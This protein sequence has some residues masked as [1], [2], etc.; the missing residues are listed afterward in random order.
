M[1]Q[2]GNEL[3]QFL[4]LFR[5]SCPEPV[6]TELAEVSKDYISDFDSTIPLFIV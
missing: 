2:I 5:I 1:T 6:Y 4:N 3:K